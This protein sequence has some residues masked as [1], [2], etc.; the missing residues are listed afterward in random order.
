MTE[1]IGS[2]V[3]GYLDAKRIQ[4]KEQDARLYHFHKA[5]QLFYDSKLN[6]GE[7]IPD[8]EQLATPEGLRTA[9]ERAESYLEKAV[10]SCFYDKD[11]NPPDD[12]RLKQLKNW[13]FGVTQ[14]NSGSGE[15]ARMGS[16]VDLLSEAVKEHKGYVSPYTILQSEQG[17]QL[18]NMAV[19]SDHT[20]LD[21]SIERLD[22]DEV[23][24]YTGIGETYNVTK[25]VFEGKKDLMS[26]LIDLRDEIPATNPI[27]REYL[28]RAGL[29]SANER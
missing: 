23:I 6:E 29:L 24:A 27:P 7:T 22:A 5:A 14:I 16:F 1:D 9:Q 17:R 26:K 13:Y 8:F 11:S 20:E 3:K 12:I 4:K 19:T 25:E 2:T 15:K 28:K 21:K 10:K 18:F